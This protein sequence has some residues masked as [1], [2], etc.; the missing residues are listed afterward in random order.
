MEEATNFNAELEMALK[1][2]AEWFN[3]ERL[4]GLVE[5]YRLLFTCVKNLN[6]VMEKKSIITPDPYKF[7][8]RISDIV[9][10]LHQ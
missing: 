7:D 5:S 1:A 4:P 3:N 8:Q 2:K 6:E 10:S 9:L